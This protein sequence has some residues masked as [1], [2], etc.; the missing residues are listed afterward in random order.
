MKKCTKCGINKPKASYYKG[1]RKETK[2]KSPHYYYSQCISCTKFFVTRHRN[3]QANKD[4]YEIKKKQW[5]EANLEKV[6]LYHREYARERMKNPIHRMQKNVSANVSN[7]L[8]R[9]KVSKNGKFWNMI[10]YS[11]DELKVH[12]E[13][14]FT[15]GMTW[16]NYGE[17]HIDHV[18]PKSLFE[19]KNFGDR[20]FMACWSLENLQP[21]WAQDNIRKGN[22]YEI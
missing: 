17:W 2:Y 9:A 21:L 22:K 12:L 5:K 11:A 6:Q 7:S 4:K 20:E 1:T 3:V 8:R 14:L 10:G 13:N 19:I 18:K 16:D 15:K